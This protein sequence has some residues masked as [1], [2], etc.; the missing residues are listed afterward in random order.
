MNTRTK[1]SL[2]LA[3]P[4][5]QP[6]LV[7]SLR[8]INRA[9]IP[10]RNLSLGRSVEEMVYFD[11]FAQVIGK[12][13]TLPAEYGLRIVPMADQNIE[14]QVAQ[15]N[16]NI[17]VTSQSEAGLSLTLPGDIKSKTESAGL[18][19][20]DPISSELLELNQLRGI[21]N[22]RDRLVISLV[23]ASRNVQEEAV[24]TSYAFD[25]AKQGPNYWEFQE[26]KTYWVDPLS[27]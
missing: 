24:N 2:V 11:R 14:E 20:S 9:E 10:T 22:F 1:E 6:L 5:Q 8:L 3:I 19:L 18:V 7:A 13:S 23:R 26:E 16:I 4:D 12:R 21:T 15:G 17:G 25:I 27:R